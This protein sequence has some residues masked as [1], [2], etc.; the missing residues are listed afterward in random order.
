MS[1][2]V[3]VIMGSKSDWSTLSHTAD[4]L[5]KL[6]IPHEVTVVSAHRTPDLL[7]QYAEQAEQRGLRVIIAGAGGAAHL[8]G[9][10]AAMTPLPVIG[11]PVKSSALSGNDS[12]LSIV[13][14]PR[15]VPVA[16]V[17]IGNAANAGLLAVRMLGMGDATLRAAMATFMASQEAEVLAKAEKLEKVGFRAYLGE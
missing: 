14:M 13:Q 3:G 15:G 7:F 16:T 11:V 4:M 12:L 8:P 17:A 5:E 9:M 10:V 1:A 2:L 6:G